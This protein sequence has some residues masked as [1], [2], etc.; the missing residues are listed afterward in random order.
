M[1]SD[2]DLEATLK[3]YRV[4]DPPAGLGPTIV[5]GTTTADGRSRYEWVWGPAAAAAIVALWV[6]VQVAMVEEPVDPARDAEVA[7]VTE[8][9]G[10][11][12]D[13]SAYAQ[14]IVPKRPFA[15]PSRMLR[16][17]PWQER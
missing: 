1:L 8:L 7:F 14:R 2:H 17:E 6:S 16:E 3:R 13:A 9:L 5:E 4:A 12:E 11:G 15:D 10:G